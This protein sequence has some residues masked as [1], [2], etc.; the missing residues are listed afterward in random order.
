V[1]GDLG[2][3][4]ASVSSALH[5]ASTFELSL[6]PMLAVFVAGH[7]LLRLRHIAQGQ[8]GSAAAAFLTL[9]AAVAVAQII[10]N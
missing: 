5:G 9:A 7:E 3:V 1:I 2:S 4:A 6:L 10:Q 8:P